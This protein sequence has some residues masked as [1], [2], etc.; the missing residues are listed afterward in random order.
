MS[1]SAPAARVRLCARASQAALAWKC[2]DGAWAKA[3]FLTSAHLLDEGVPSVIT[4]GIVQGERGVGERGVVAPGV[5][6]RA[7]SGG[8][9]LRR[10]RA[11]DAAHDQTGGDLLLLR[12]GSEGGV[13]GLGYLG[14]GDPALALLVP[15]RLG[16][17]DRR[18]G[19][20]I[21]GA[22]VVLTEAFIC[23]VMEKR[24]PS[25]RQ[26]LTASAP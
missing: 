8:D 21:V 16:V 2:P 12:L 13:G 22:M 15:D 7:L 14:V 1:A 9:G 18:P 6:Q 23:T 26:E 3:L 19:V 11:F 10:A 4:L 25:A 20:L 17:L 24:A 5:K